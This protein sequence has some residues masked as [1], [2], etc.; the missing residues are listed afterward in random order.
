M[1]PRS[2]QLWVFGLAAGARGQAYRKHRPLARLARN[3]HVTTHHPGKEPLLLKDTLRS[4]REHRD[5]RE[6][7]YVA[8]GDHISSCRLVFF[9]VISGDVGSVRR[10][11]V[12]R[13]K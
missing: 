5:R 10:G 11:G 12:P 7:P 13:L 3:R 9:E 2:P 4:R 1:R 6:G 8:L